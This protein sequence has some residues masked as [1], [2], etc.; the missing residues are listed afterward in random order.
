MASTDLNSDICE[1]LLEQVLLWWPPKRAE[2]AQP[3]QIS[4]PNEQEEKA[5]KQ[6]FSSGTAKIMA[7]LG[8]GQSATTSLGSAKAADVQAGFLQSCIVVPEI[9]GGMASRRD[10]IVGCFC[11]DCEVRT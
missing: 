9:S 5:V 8:S 2:R 4:A 7:H 3:G 6:A 1:M 10:K 11:R